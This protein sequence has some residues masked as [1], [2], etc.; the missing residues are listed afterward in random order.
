PPTGGTGGGSGGGGDTGGGGVNGGGAG[1]SGGGMDLDGGSDAG[2]PPML[3]LTKV[4][5]PRGPSA[6]GSSVTLVG[7]AFLRD[8][9]GT[10]SLAKPVTQL[11]FGANSVIDYTIIDD[12]TIELR[13]PPGT[14]GTASVSIKN[15]NGTFLCN[16]CFTYYDELV[17]SSAAPKEGP[18]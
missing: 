15:P 8:F 7:S 3:K 18:M 10:G 17:L 11:K 9:A 6:G 16:S 5:P 4:L 1:G 14:T 13:V 2:P 12:D